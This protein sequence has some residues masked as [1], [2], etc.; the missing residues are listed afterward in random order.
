MPERVQSSGTLEGLLW[1]AL[2]ARGVGL[3]SLTKSGLHPQPAAVFVERRR[4]RLWLAV[5][6]DSELARGVGEGGAAIFTAQGP[7]MLASIGGSLTLEDD[8]RRLARLWAAAQAQAW[9]PKGSTETGLCLMQLRCVDAEVSLA[10]A[11][12]LRFSWDIAP[13]TPRARAARRLAP[14]HTTLH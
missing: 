9:R 4:R 11:D 10:D 12:H 1:E 6:A 5:A 13:A 3:L 7:G 2:E 14:A 8:P